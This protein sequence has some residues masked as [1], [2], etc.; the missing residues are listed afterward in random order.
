MNLNRKP[1]IDIG[2]TKQL[3]IDDYVISEMDNCR[4]QF[5]RPKRVETNPLIEADQ[6]WEQGNDGVY[7]YGGSVLFDE[8]EQLFK[9]WYQ[10][11][12]TSEKNR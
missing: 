6:S 1:S 7:L 4:R 9:M 8:E 12:M 5:H 10:L 3:F 11:D 2:T